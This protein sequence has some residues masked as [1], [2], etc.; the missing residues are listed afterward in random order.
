VVPKSFITLEATQ[1]KSLFKTS[2]L[3]AK[4][5]LVATTAQATVV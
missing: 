3:A 5:K 1:I 4:L 2:W